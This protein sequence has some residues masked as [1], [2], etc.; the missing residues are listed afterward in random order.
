[1]KAEADQHFLQGIN[2]L[3]GHGWPY[4][5]PGVEYPGWRFYAAGAFDEKNPWW[6][7]MPD[8]ALYLQRV[9]FM[10]RQGE[11]ANDIALYLP[12]SDGWAHLSA[13]HVHMIETLRELIGPDIVARLIDSG[14]NFDFFDD[15]ALKQVGR[16]E[17]ER[18]DLGPN[19]YRAVVLPGVERI[20]L[21]TLLKLEE[22]ARSGGVLIA[23]RRVPEHAPGL[24]ANDAEQNQI[25]EISQRLFQ[26]RYGAAHFVKDETGDLPGLLASLLRPDVRMAPNAPDIGFVHRKSQD[27]EI[28]FL[29]NTSN[30]R[31]SVMATFRVTGMRPQW[32]DPLTG[33]VSTAASQDDGADGTKVPL[34]LE[35]YGSRVLVF[36][37][38]VPL[39]TGQKASIIPPAIDLS[40]GWKVSFGEGP[41]VMMERLRSWTEDEGTRYFS[42]AANY[43][44]QFAVPGNMFQPD[45]RV[46]LDFGESRAIPAQRL[47]NGMQAWLDAPVREAAVVYVNGQRAGSV[48]CPPYSLDVTGLLRTGENR[49]RVEV[50]NLAVNYM[51]GRRLP[52]YRLLNLRYGE[53]FQ[54]QDMEK[55]Q[56]VQAGLL[57]TIRLVPTSGS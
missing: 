15:E 51:A 5:A 4:T 6:I 24:L 22:F 3:I 38:N 19:K 23:T 44:K 53:R 9:S 31:Q 7:A 35:P 42:G 11:P 48:W 10:M 46:R 26:E 40:T 52:D 45:L 39:P 13:G 30:V 2:Q 49:I 27:A 56:P 47:K 8:L 16:V 12:N 17:R 54:P 1:M 32:W 25:R 50:A 36:S 55:I 20:P 43:E 33:N 18:L 28:Y 21:D 34:D 41:P 37:N 57:G 14:Y 29:A